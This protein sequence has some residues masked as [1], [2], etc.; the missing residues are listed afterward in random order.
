MKLTELPLPERVDRTA[1]NVLGGPLELCSYDPLTGF[2]R[3][4][5]CE[6]GADDLG[7]HTVCIIADEAFLAASQAAGNDLS[8]ATGS[9][10]GLQPGD[11]WCLCANRWREAY[12]RGFAPRVVLAATHAATLEIVPLRILLAYAVTTERPN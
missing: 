12:E 9:F 3:T 11:R 8:T 10:P 1:K 5:C 7:L 6:T 2:Y 4:A